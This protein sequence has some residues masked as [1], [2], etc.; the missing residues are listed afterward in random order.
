MVVD[1]IRLVCW[2]ATSQSGAKPRHVVLSEVD[3][4]LMC[5]L[6]PVADLVEVVEEIVDVVVEVVKI[7][8]R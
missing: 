6:I 4:R 1:D 3:I 5:S 8:R 7:E 2:L